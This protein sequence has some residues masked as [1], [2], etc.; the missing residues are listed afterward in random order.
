MNNPGRTPHALPQLPSAHDIERATLLGPSECPRRY[1]WWWHSLS[2]D[3]D[4]PVAAGCTFVRDRE[5]GKVDP[6]WPGRELPCRRAFPESPADH[7]EPQD[8]A[9][10]EDGVSADRWKRSV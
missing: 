1:C 6:N 3:W 4:T 2:F 5:R 7:F 9:L 8:A 10:A